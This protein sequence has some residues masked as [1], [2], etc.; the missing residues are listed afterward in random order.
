M[1]PHGPS[2]SGATHSHDPDFP[3]DDWNLYSMLAQETTSLNT[4]RPLQTLGFT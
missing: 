2:M 4:S 1:P 3:E